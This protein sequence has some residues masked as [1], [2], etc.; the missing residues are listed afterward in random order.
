MTTKCFRSLSITVGLAFANM[1]IAQ[2]AAPASSAAPSPAAATPGGSADANA[3]AAIAP[4]APTAASGSARARGTAARGAATGAAPAGS[5]AVWDRPADGKPVFTEDFESGAINDKTWTLHIAGSPTA[6]VV[7]DKVAHGKYALKIHYPAKTTSREWAFIG[8]PVPEALRNHFYGRAY[9]YMDALPQGHCVY[10]NAGSPGWPVS[11]F[12][13][14]G[15]RQNLFQPSFQM[16]ATRPGFED[17]PSEG[18][19]PVGRWFCLE[20]EFIENPDRIVMWIDGKLS[21]NRAFSMNGKKDG[22]TGGF[23]EFNLGFRSWSAPAKDVDIY[24]DD[25]AIGDKPIGQLAPAAAPDAAKTGHF[26][27]SGCGF[28]QRHQVNISRHAL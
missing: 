26:R 12:L 27:R 7:Q 21:V 25:I 9:V 11:N 10:M 3:P 28:R 14:I 20:W 17:H 18:V 13:E 23:F 15:S 6:T 16:N 2:P 8:I 4:A 22:L 1:S 19:P 5:V 24:Y